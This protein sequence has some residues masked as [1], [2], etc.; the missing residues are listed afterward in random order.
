MNS[1]GWREFTGEWE[2][3]ERESGVT[4]AQRTENPGR[5]QKP[6]EGWFR[7]CLHTHNH[8]GAYRAQTLKS[9]FVEEETEVQTGPEVTH[10][11]FCPVTTQCH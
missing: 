3:A 6:W 4:Q 8:V 2:G 1:G 5:P 11:S 7:N 10:L 9:I